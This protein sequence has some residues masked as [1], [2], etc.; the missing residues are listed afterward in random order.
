M[1]SNAS[2]DLPEPERPVKTTNWSRGMATSM[3]LRL[4]SRAPRM[5]IWRASRAGLR[6]RSVMLPER[7]K[8]DP[9]LP[10]HGGEISRVQKQR[11]GARPALL[12]LLKAPLP[13]AVV[14]ADPDNAG[15]ERDVRYGAAAGHGI[16]THLAKIGVEIFELG[17]P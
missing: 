9:V 6:V 16:A 14:Q 17:R 8:N 7:S 10:V 13:E 2:E 4:C 1:V 11:A 12:N 3:F 15:L 5:V